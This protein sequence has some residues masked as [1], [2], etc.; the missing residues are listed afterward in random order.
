MVYTPS[1]I[2][3]AAIALNIVSPSL[4]IPFKLLADEQPRNVDFIDSIHPIAPAEGGPEARNLAA[5]LAGGAINGV[6]KEVT[7][8][9][10]EE[11]Q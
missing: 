11:G 3:A 9:A 4:A 5:D 6:T 8:L 2:L 1:A 10:I 7:E